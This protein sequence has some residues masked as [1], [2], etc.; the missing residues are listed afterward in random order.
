MFFKKRDQELEEIKNTLKEIEIFYSRRLEILK[1]RDAEELNQF[2]EFK[3]LFKDYKKAI[4]EFIDLFRKDRYISIEN[5]KVAI[6]F[7]RRLDEE[8]RS[9]QE[10]CQSNKL[11]LLLNKLNPKEIELKP[12]SKSQSSYKDWIILPAN[13]HGDY[14]YPDLLVSINKY[15]YNKDWYKCHS[16]LHK[17]G[18]FMLTIRQFVDF[19]N[20]LR[21][22][23]AKYADGSSVPRN[24]QDNLFM[25]I[26]EVLYPQTAEWL[27]AKFGISKITYHK[28]NSDGTYKEVTEPLKDCC[29]TEAN[30]PGINLNYWLSNANHQGLL[31]KNNLY[32][33]LSDWFPRRGYVA[34]FNVYSAKAGSVH[35]RDPKKSDWE[36]GVRRAKIFSGYR[37]GGLSI[38]EPNQE[39]Q[40]S[41]SKR[42]GDL[43]FTD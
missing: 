42:K 28:I 4:K 29:L 14:S 22:G 7:S 2:K 39:G 37:K 10:D 19:L 30:L 3:K 41:Y 40:L 34:W 32:G 20:L 21:S 33:N 36:I 27:D 16:L 6:D 38:S 15:H 9:E 11:I 23:N 13:K 24:I 31:R 26:A 17:E 35:D 5:L 43:S 1:Q 8:L 18:C 25:W 12:M